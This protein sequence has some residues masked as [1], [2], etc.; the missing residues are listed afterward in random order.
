MRGGLNLQAH[1]DSADQPLLIA[2]VTQKVSLPLDQHAAAEMHAIVQAGESILLGE[3]IA[4]AADKLGPWL[5]SPVSGVVTAIDTQ[6]S[7]HSL[8]RRV[9]TIHIASD[10]K[11]ERD[12]AMQPLANPLEIAPSVLRERLAHG[13]IV[14]LGGAVFSTAAKLAVADQ[15]NVTTLIVNGAECEPFITCDDVLMRTHAQRVVDGVQI[16]LHACC[17]GTAIIAIE[18]NKNAAFNAIND[19]LRTLG[20]SRI[21]AVAVPTIYPAGGERQLINTVT[22]KEVPSG[23]LPADIG[24]ICHNVGTAAA[25]STL[26]RTGEPL[27]RR[28]VTITGSGVTT[29]QSV[30]ARI[31]TP[32]AALIEACGGYAEKPKQLVMGGSMMGIALPNDG[33]PIVKATNCIVAATAQDLPSRG[34]EL[35]CIRCGECAT[36]CPANLLPQELLRHLRNDNRDALNKLGLADCIECGC[37][38]YV[39]PSQIRLTA[40]FIAGKRILDD[41]AL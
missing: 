17:A 23:G 5:H 34:P 27:I 35:P 16:L 41:T 19:A 28:I 22:G 31:G 18:S 20:D 39:C 21:Q 6:R 4:R 1:K 7:P 29:P 32:I 40:N 9:T 10:G 24:M 37:C 2:P 14:G 26:V 36:A 11:D 12:P 38:D 30:E 15:L 3:V 33:L 8:S 13:G 25:V